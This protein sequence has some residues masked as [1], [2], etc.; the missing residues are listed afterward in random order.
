M[1]SDRRPLQVFVPQ[2]KLCLRAD[3]SSVIAL[4]LWL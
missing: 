2:G 4:L 3:Q 1:E